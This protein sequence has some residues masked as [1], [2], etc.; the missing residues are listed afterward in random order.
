MR[1]IPALIEAGVSSLKIEGRMKSAYYIAT[2]VHAYRMLIDEYAQTGTLNEERIAFYEEEIAKAENR[3][4]G[5]GFYL[6]MPKAKDQLYGVNGAGVTQEYI[7]DVLSYDE[8]SQT[9]L[10]Q[11]RNHFHPHIDAEVF[12]PRTGIDPFSNRRGLRPGRSQAGRAQPADAA[13]PGEMRISPGTA[14]DDP[15]GL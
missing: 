9:A 4:T 2:V 13:G 1:F 14:R 5:P 10:L 12:G 11:V 7:A 6:G 15:Q 8:R 3:P